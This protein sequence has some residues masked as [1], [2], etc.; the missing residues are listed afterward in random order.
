MSFSAAHQ[1]QFGY[2]A[3]PAVVAAG[4]HT[5]GLRA[6]V[7]YVAPLNLLTVEGISADADTTYTA[8][9]VLGGMILRSGLTAGRTD[10]LPTAALLVAAYKGCVVGSG[11]RFI[12]RNV[13]GQTLTIAEGAGMTDYAGNTATLATVRSAEHMI[14]F[15]NV[16]LGAEACTLYTLSTANIH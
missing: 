4:A 5:S 3:K 12:V 7:Q 8:E 10:T 6:D 14:V 11:V 1:S 13:S 15:D 16:T 2:L 9:E